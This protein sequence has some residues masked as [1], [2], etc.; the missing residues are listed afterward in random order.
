M[1]NSDSSDQLYHSTMTLDDLKH[2]P[3]KWM[4]S[5]LL[6]A[7]DM[8]I[9][10]FSVLFVP[11]VFRPIFFQGFL[12]STMMTLVG[13][14]LIFIGLRWRGHYLFSELL[15]SNFAPP[16][17]ITEKYSATK[18][19]NTYIFTLKGRGYF[20]CFAALKQSSIVSSDKIRVPNIIWE[21]RSA[22]HVEGLTVRDVEGTFSV[23][24]PEG[25]I[26]SGEGLLLCVTNWRSYKTHITKE[27]LHEV[28]EYAE[29]YLSEKPDDSEISDEGLNSPDE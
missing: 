7:P 25:N 9:F 20:L 21:V 14:G 2:K 1:L 29:K 22:Y 19:G 12:V 4:V 24:T 15:Q 10:M 13:F 16:I 27:N 26:I 28:A 5:G 6:L 3:H 8:F 18:H 11:N 23:P 17:Y